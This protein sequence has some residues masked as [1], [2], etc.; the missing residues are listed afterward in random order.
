MPARSSASLKLKIIKQ[1]LEDSQETLQQS[2]PVIQQWLETTGLTVDDL[3]KTSENAPEYQSSPNVV[4]TSVSQQLNQDS[5]QDVEL[6]HT[7]TLEEHQAIIYKLREVAKLNPGDLEQ[8]DLL[9][10]EQQLSDIFGF[11]VTSKLDDH[12]LPFTLGTMAAAP[13]QRRYPKDK[14]G[15]H[16]RYPEAGMTQT[17]SS[18]GWMLEAGQLSATATKQEQYGL[19]LPLAYL[20]EWQQDYSQLK[21]WYRYRKMLVINP[22]ELKAIIASVINIDLVS[23]LKYQFAGT[24]ELIRAGFIWSPKASGRVLVFFINDEP[25]NIKVGPINLT[26]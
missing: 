13:H 4:E 12:K 11:E 25:D 7:I 2:H 26:P 20:P 3:R 19:S 8:D 15:E 18:F 14:L 10:L 5:Q 23:T 6:L 17:R 9:Y 22:F 21:D 1:Y 24:P 16:N